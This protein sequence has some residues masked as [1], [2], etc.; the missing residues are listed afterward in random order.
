MKTETQNIVSPMPRQKPPE[1]VLN[2]GR[3]VK[4]HVG[5]FGWFFLDLLA[6]SVAMALAH[7]VSPPGGFFDAITWQA[8][9]IIAYGL[10]VAVVAHVFGLHD[11]L[12]KR[13]RTMLL[14]K[15]ASISTISLVLLELIVLFV[16]YNR[17]GRHT[18]FFAF[19]LTTFSLAAMRLLLWQ[20]SDQNKKRL[21]LVWDGQIPQHIIGLIEENRA[22]YQ[23][24]ALC[25]TQPE[26]E[27]AG[28]NRYLVLSNEVPIEEHCHAHAIDE[29]VVCQAEWLSGEHLGEILKCMNRGIMVRDYASFMEHNFHKIPVEHIDP[30]WFFQLNTSGDYFIF[31]GFKR[32]MDILL[33][34]TG[35]LLGAPVL[36][37]LAILIKI[38]SRGSVFYSQ[39]R[40]G[41][42]DRPFHIWK[43][44]SM[45]TDAEVNGPRW[46]GKNDQRVT[47]VGRI[48]RKTR[49]DELPQFWNILVGNMSFV[50]PRPERPKFVEELAGVIPFYDQRHLV[51][52][53]LT[54]WAQIN[55]PYGASQEDALQKLKY[56]LYYVRNASL[57]L[58]VHIIL[59]TIGA[60]MKGAR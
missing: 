42:Y 9:T 32:Q 53:G 3:S 47:R 55:Y 46:A 8:L 20:I 22:P 29:V 37:L 27:G 28:F 45:R 39:V 59:R 16:F 14:V 34:L 48:I 43:L 58:D 17:V 13:Y 24:V 1:G 7:W 4:W 44:R 56:D 5:S 51:K 54:G 18:L 31:Q 19:I 23:V 11:T 36:L 12:L 35:M 52:P 10:M 2:N 25:G 6:A 38:E 26:F 50:G 40:V 15:C 33:S 49:L 41:Q 60:V 21:L 30:A 57:F